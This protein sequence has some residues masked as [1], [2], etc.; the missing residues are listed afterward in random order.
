[1]DFLISEKNKISFSTYYNGSELD[2]RSNIDEWVRSDLAFSRK[3]NKGKELYLKVKN[4]FDKDYQD[5]YG[6]GTEGL[7]FYIGLR[8]NYN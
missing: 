7:S 5:V 2:S 8:L 3:L 4:I 1:M 6:Y